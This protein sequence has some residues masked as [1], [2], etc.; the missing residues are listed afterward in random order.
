[1][2][3][4]INNKKFF[5]NRGSLTELYNSYNKKYAKFMI[6]QILMIESK[7]NVIRGLHFQKKIL[8]EKILIILEGEILDVIINLKNIKKKKI[9][10]NKLNQKNNSLLIP[11]GY[12]HGYQVLSNKCKIMYFIKGRYIKKYQTGIKWDD[13]FLNIKWSIKKPIISAKDNDLPYICA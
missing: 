1:M 7:K 9:I 5:D 11:K 6:N 4:L 8:Q 10:Y 3:K 12:A 13:P 2:T